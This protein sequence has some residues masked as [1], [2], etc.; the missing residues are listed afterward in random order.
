MNII[1]FIVNYIFI[2]YFF[3]VI[4]V[5]IFLYKFGQTLYCLTLDKSRK[6]LTEGVAFSWLIF[7]KR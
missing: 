6:R 7:Y 4:N 2:I 1:I 5:F 3:S